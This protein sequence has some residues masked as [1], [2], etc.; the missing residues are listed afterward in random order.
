[1]GKH[2]LQRR[3]DLVPTPIRFS[4]IVPPPPPPL[5]LQDWILLP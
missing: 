2:F 5:S 3:L 4:V 1:M